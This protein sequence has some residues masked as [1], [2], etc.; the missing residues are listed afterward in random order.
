LAA[1][2]I[3]LTALTAT[4]E[5][6]GAFFAALSSSVTKFS[7]HSDTRRSVALVNSVLVCVATS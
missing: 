3:C 4:S 1:A 6:A 5:P 2:S 7:F